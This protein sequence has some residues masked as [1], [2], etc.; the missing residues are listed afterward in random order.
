MLLRVWSTMFALAVVPIIPITYIECG[1]MNLS[2]MD[3]FDIT[4]SWISAL[5]ALEFHNSSKSFGSMQYNVAFNQSAIW[6]NIIAISK[7]MKWNKKEKKNIKKW[8]PL[9]I[10]WQIYVIV[11]HVINPAPF[12]CHSSRVKCQY[13]LKYQ[14]EQVHFWEKATQPYTGMPP[15]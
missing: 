8:Q 15:I 1:N 3:W 9:L 4:L 6:P 13:R 2:Y 7:A 12:Q 14:G 11:I 5:I 10:P